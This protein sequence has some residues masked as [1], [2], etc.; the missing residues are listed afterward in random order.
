MLTTLVQEP[1]IDGIVE[2]NEMMMT[3][4]TTQL[5]ATFNI[6][7]LAHSISSKPTTGLTENRRE[8]TIGNKR[9]I[10]Q[11]VRGTT[12]TFAPLVGIPY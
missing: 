11:H 2:C 1:E 8:V 7:G 3:V 5:E 9:S 10:A 4:S 12:V 6:K